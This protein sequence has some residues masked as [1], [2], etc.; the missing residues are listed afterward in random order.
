M[1]ILIIEDD[2]F[3]SWKIKNVFQSQVLTNRI[4]LVHS[5]QDFYRISSILESFDIVLT[6]IQLSNT[7]G[8]KDG[9]EVI[10]MIRKKDIKIPIVVISGSGNIND[11]QYAFH[12]WASDYIIKPVRLQELEVRILNWY[13][14]IYLSHISFLWK[15]CYYKELSYHLDTNEFYFQ[16]TSINLTKGS[17][18]LLS[19]FFT[20]R[21]KLLS[22]HFLIEKIWGDMYMIIERNLRT[23]IFRLKKWLSQFWIDSRIENIRWEWYI[24]IAK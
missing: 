5:L 9:F 4:S 7:Y 3:L 2:V 10:K 23:N 11:L 13:T 12:I 18:Y 8:N 1:N 24:F 16:N 22:E 14:N 21:E 6:D 20:H 15:I 19:L 17:K